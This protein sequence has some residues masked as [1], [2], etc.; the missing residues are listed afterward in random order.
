[1]H[2][3]ILGLAALLLVLLGC[4]R[5]E[6]SASTCALTADGG[7]LDVS[8]RADGL[9]GI[10]D[11]AVAATPIAH[12]ERMVRTG[13]GVDPQCGKRWVGVR[14]AEEEARALKDFTATPEGRGMAVVVSGQVASRHKIR[15]SIESAELQVSCCDPKACDRWEALLASDRR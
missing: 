12:F 13:A 7:M 10:V 8:G 15:Q 9:Y 6:P 14:L 4:H 5:A 3:R 2:R 11:D 1:M